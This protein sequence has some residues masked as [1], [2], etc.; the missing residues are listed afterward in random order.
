MTNALH[1]KT[2]TEAAEFCGTEAVL[3]VP[4]ATRS[5]YSYPGIEDNGG[6]RRR[7]TSRTTHE[8]AQ[9]PGYK[10]QTM[11][12]TVRDQKRAFNILAWMIRRSLDNVSRFTPHVDTGDLDVDDALN[13]CLEWHALKKNFDAMGRLSRDEWFRQ[14]EGCKIIG[15]DC[16]GMKCQGVKLQGIEGDRIG[17][18]QGISVASGFAF[19]NGWWISEEG[20][21]FEGANTPRMDPTD[22]QFGNRIVGYGVCRRSGIRGNLLTLERIVPT[23]NME[24]DAYW[25]ERFDSNRGVS[26]ILPVLNECADMMEA[27]EFLI[28]KIKIGALFGWGFVRTGDDEMAN[29]LGTRSASTGGTSATLPNDTATERTN[30]A[31]MIQRAIDARGPIVLDLDEG[32]K[33]QEIE[34][35]TPNSEVVPF[36]R[37]IARSILLALDLPFTMYDSMA[38]S[39]SANEQA[40]NEFDEACVWKRE[41]NEALLR[42]IYSAHWAVGIF[43]T[44]DLFGLGKALRKAGMDVENAAAG[45]DWY[46]TGRPQP[47]TDEIKG[48]ILAI[49]AGL[50]SP[51]RWCAR[52]GADAFQ[53]AKEVKKYLSR[54]GGTMPLFWAAG[55]QNSVQKIM[56]E[57]TGDPNTPAPAAPVQ[58]GKGKSK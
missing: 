55:G 20:L 15:G 24:F 31:P 4:V 29:G 48:G 34:S 22:I 23:E 36:T 47:T 3:T 26:P 1:E 45:I 28:L 40:R 39:Y 33:M 58:P 21:V 37:E 11:S 51:Q 38:S 13:K 8:L 57:P 30:Y 43:A 19:W 44:C 53:I 18:G 50:S 54:V 12:A 52:H 6:R 10:R 41:K 46:P 9:L 7:V 27:R 35:S 32:D 49:S 2:M 14:F 56:D 42:S 17:V 16:G 25:P 5:A